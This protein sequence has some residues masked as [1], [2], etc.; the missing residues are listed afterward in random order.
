MKK[1]DYNFNGGDKLKSMGAGWFISYTYYMTI[2]SNNHNWKKIKT[3]TQ[4]RSTYKNTLDYHCYWISKIINMDINKLGKNK[5]ELSGT[6]IKTMAQIL[7][8]KWNELCVNL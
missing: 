4:R 2:D 7:Y 1:H 8:K 5:I 3:I 6:Q